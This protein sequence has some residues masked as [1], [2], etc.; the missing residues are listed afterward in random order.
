MF[1]TVLLIK[2][3]NRENLFSE[4]IDA[5][6]KKVTTVS[7]RDAQ[8]QCSQMWR[9]LKGKNKANSELKEAVC[10]LI[11]KWKKN[12]QNYQRAQFYRFGKSVL[13]TSL[14]SEHLFFVLYLLAA[15]AG[16]LEKRFR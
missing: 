5:Y 14:V 2:S 16:I 6:K 10:Y 1:F 15:E 4:L 8:L 7:G 12:A 13:Q 9:E 3:E 11:E